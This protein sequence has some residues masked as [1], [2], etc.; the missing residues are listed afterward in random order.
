[1]FA[2][3]IAAPAQVF[4]TLASFNGNNGA[5]PG[6]G[7]LIQG[8]DGAFYGTT[9]QGGISGLGTAFRIT[10][11]G[12]LT[13]INCSDGD[14]PSAGLVLATDRNFYGTT[15][16]GGSGGGD[17]GTVFRITPTGVVT[18]LYNSC[19]QAH[20]S[21]GDY[22]AA[23]LVQG[24][25]GD[26]Y[27]TTTRGGD[28]ACNAPSGCG[29]VFKITAAGKLT[30]LH[31][32]H[33]SDGAAPWAGGLVQ[34]ID[35]RFYGTTE[36]GGLNNHGTVFKITKGGTLTTLHS[37]DGADGSLPI[38]RLIQATD[39]DF[40][41]TTSAGGIGNC[42]NNCGTVFKI[43]P[44][45]ALTT[46]HSFNG[47]DGSNPSGAL[48]QATDGNLYG[49]TQEGGD[50]ACNR[51]TGCGT[52]FKITPVG[53]LT[54]LHIFGEGAFPE[55][56]LLQSTNGAFYGA[57]NENGPSGNGT[58]FGLSTGLGP[59]VSFV[60]NPAKVDQPFG[61]LGEGFTG[62][63]TVTLNGKSVPFTVNSDTLIT[64]TI[65][66]GSTTGPV[67]VT[68]QTGALASNAPFRVLPQLLSFT[69]MSGPVGTEV[70]ITGISL[71]QTTAVKFGDYVSAN[72]TVNSDTQVT[73]IVPRNVTT[74]FIGIQT[75]GGHAISTQTFTVT[76]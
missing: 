26:F 27:G 32:F 76:Q 57:T 75:K 58:I 4:T 31:S 68:T 49:M 19:S 60:R 53:T 55:G 38:G 41:G 37:F 5:Y 73:A 43:S 13:S 1:M 64:A 71:T 56:G 74:G 29:T 3:A 62:T 65:P 48:V 42:P 30:T 67:T 14:S 46:L 2:T 70:T 47:V 15:T 39:G 69:P 17:G 7:S 18:T 9:A 50:T 25:D 28:V 21:D 23:G 16:F 6:Y 12:A 20:C 72:F 11:G 66:A 59:F 45:G 63:T 61:I 22:V 10:P 33:F 44:R 35:G 51:G 40:Y 34:G 24:D 8:I 36:I 54:T 52:V